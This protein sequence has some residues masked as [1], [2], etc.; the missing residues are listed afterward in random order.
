MQR[1]GACGDPVSAQQIPLQAITLED[2]FSI[3]PNPATGF[4]NLEYTGPDITGVVVT[5]TDLGGKIHLISSI[6]FHELDYGSTLDISMLESGLYIIG[7][8][9]GNYQQY[10][11]LLI[12]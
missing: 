6:G 1:F 11:K 9:T 7:L 5:I 4:V 2:R 12:E 10:T 8:S 3:L